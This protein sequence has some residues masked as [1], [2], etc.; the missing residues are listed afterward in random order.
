MESSG[1]RKAGYWAHR[2]TAAGRGPQNRALGARDALSIEGRWGHGFSQHP[3]LV[4]GLAGSQGQVNS[5][6]DLASVVSRGRGV[7]KAMG[8]WHW[9][10]VTP[11][12]ETERMWRLSWPKTSRRDLWLLWWGFTTLFGTCQEQPAALHRPWLK[13]TPCLWSPSFCHTA[14]GGL[15]S[16]A[17]QPLLPTRTGRAAG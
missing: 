4:V 12:S 10:L 3:W 16:G 6:R 8:L 15:Q 7:G 1:W 13:T 5:G 17:L 9:R 11:T 14:R 2:E